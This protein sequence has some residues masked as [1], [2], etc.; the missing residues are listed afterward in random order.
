[1]CT[2]FYIDWSN[3]LENN[4]KLIHTTMQVGVFDSTLNLVISQVLFKNVCLK[5]IVWIYVEKKNIANKI[6]E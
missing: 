3:S 1:M 2:L 6:I 5:R 4:Y